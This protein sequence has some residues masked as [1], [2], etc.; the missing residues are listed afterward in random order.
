MKITVIS[1]APSVLAIHLVR[2]VYERGFG[3]GRNSCEV[4]FDEDIFVP[5][6]G[7]DIE[8]SKVIDEPKNQRYRLR[9]VVTHKGWH[10]SGHYTCYRRR[11]REWK[12]RRLAMEGSSPE[13]AEKAKA[14]DLGR[15][16]SQEDL[17]MVKA[18]NIDDDSLPTE[19]P[20]S[21]TKWWEISDEIVAG[22]NR[23]DVLSKKKGVY[24][25]FYEKGLPK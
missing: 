23:A 18:L 21:R 25:L 14:S 15:D 10:D 9:S 8:E 1:K 4:S 24:I 16:L 22:V 19:L 17:G 7:E 2:S 13:L 6:S 12:P 5:L 11:K 20:D 3:A